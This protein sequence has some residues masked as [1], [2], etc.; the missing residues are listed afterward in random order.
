[1]GRFLA[2]HNSKKRKSQHCGISHTIPDY[3]ILAMPSLFFLCSNPEEPEAAEWVE[4]EEE[5]EEKKSNTV[6]G[7][8]FSS[9]LLGYSG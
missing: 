4:E 9:A 1:M 5:E 3:N 7:K 8:K 6:S 2:L